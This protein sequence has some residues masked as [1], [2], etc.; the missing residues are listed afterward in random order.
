MS[1]DA[2]PPDSNLPATRTDDD[3]R[4]PAR[5]PG[6]GSVPLAR[7]REG[8]R[9]AG[10]DEGAGR[11]TRASCSRSSRAATR[12]PSASSELFYFDASARRPPRRPL[13]LH[14]HATTRRRRSSTGARARTAPSRCCSIRTPGA[15]TAASSLGMAGARAGTASRSPTRSEH[16]TGRGHRCTCSTSPTGK[17]QVDVIE[18]AQVRRPLVDARRRRLLLHVAAHATRRSRSAERPGYAELRF[19]KLGT[20]SDE[21]RGRPRA[22][23]RPADVPRRRPSRDGHWLFALIQHGWNA[24]DVYLRCARQGE[25]LAAARRGRGRELRR[26]RLAGPLL[27][28][29]N[30]GAPR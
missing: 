16:N 27:R 24:N 10:V 8:A 14:A 9:G 19:H 2:R 13:L 1:Q 28:T 23:R 18:G 25:G 21:G 4:H 17:V 30:D 20:R 5:H 12:S 6:G 3:R 15:R 7:G 29:T 11:L 22:H 26:R